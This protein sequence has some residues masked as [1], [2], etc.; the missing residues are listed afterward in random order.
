MK[1]R[2]RGLVKR[3]RKRRM[4]VGEERKLRKDERG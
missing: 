2:K 1:E 3:T 4:N